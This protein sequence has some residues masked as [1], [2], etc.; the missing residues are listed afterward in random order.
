M[1]VRPSRSSAVKFMTATPAPPKRQPIFENVEEDNVDSKS[2]KRKL[3][4]S[5]DDENDEN[6]PKKLKIENIEKTEKVAKTEERTSFEGNQF[7]TF[8][9]FVCER[10]TRKL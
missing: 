9:D 7:V 10:T 6:S 5:F 8:E 2:T 3:S 1:T 4:M